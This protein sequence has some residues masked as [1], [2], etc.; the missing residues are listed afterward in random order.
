MKRLVLRSTPFSSEAAVASL[1]QR[2]HVLLFTLFVAVVAAAPFPVGAD[3]PPKVIKLGCLFVDPPPGSAQDPGFFKVFVQAM[4]K[5]G[6]EEGKNLAITAR[7]ANG[8]LDDLNR[9][10]EELAALELD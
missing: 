2:I 6:Y 9:M 4:R 3:N 10:A 5:L 8:K 7:F 1:L